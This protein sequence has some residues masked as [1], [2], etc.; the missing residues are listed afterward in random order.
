MALSVSVRSASALAAVLA[1]TVSTAALA[2]SYGT[3]DMP[4]GVEAKPDVLEK[5]RSLKAPAPAARA[6]AN[7]P[8]VTAPPMDDADAAVGAPDPSSTDTDG[9]EYND[10][11]VT[12]YA[13]PD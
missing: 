10:N 1:L 9:K 4:G 12:P 3:E 5:S 11:K 13:D 7:A 8:E 2:Q 6:P